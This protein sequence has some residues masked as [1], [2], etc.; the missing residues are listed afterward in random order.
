MPSGQYFHL[1][2]D[3]GKRVDAITLDGTSYASKGSTFQPQ[4]ERL[5]TFHIGTGAELKLDTTLFYYLPVQLILGAYYG[6]D[7]ALNPNGVFPFL[8]I[9][10]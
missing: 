9:G 10:I 7:T 4:I 8:G 3:G 5:G 2:F 6:T 1:R